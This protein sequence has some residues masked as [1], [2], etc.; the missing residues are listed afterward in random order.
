MDVIQFI[1]RFEDLRPFVY[2]QQHG[3][4]LLVLVHDVLR[5]EVNSPFRHILSNNMIVGSLFDL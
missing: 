5:M 2:G 1:K 3:P 4:A